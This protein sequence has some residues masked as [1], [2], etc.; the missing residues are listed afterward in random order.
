MALLSSPRLTQCTRLAACASS[1]EASS[2]IAITAISIPWLRAPSSTR[3]GN[4]PFPAISPQPSLFV[5]ISRTPATPASAGLLLLHDPA[6]RLLHKTHQLLYVRGI[7][8]ALPQLFQRLRSVLLGSH[9]YPERSL[10]CFDPLARKS[11][12]LQPDRIRAKAFRFPLRH[13][14]R[15]WQHILRDYRARPDVRITPQSAELVHRRK[16]ANRDKILYGD[17][18]RQ[19]CSIHEQRV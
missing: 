15:K 3:N 17:V 5:F 16:R 4:R 1:G 18:S 9:Q 8:P 11:L 2:L 10:Q 19:C 7:F 13:H 6:L 12:A 14:Q